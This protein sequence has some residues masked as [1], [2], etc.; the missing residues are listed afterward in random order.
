MTLSVDER[1]SLVRSVGEECIQEEELRGLLE[2][3]EE[4]I[5]YDGF[6]PCGRVH[7]G[8]G[9]V[10]ALTVQKLLKAGCRF[11]FWVADY[12][13]FLNNKM[14]GDMKKIQNIGKYM[15]EVWKAL[16]LNLDKVEFL[17]A[18]EE[19]NK[20]PGSYW[21]LVMDIARK[22]K[23]PRILNCSESMGRS[24]AGDVM[25]AQIM[26]PCMQ[27]ADILYLGADICQLGTDQQQ[28]NL[29]ARDY[30]DESGRAQKPVIVS[31]HVLRGLQEGQEKIVLGDPSSAIYM[32][33]TEVEV[34]TKIKK[35]FCPPKVTQGNPC[36]EYVKYVVLPAC[37]TFEV[38][39][40]DQNGGNKVYSS[41]DDLIADYES[42]ALHP[43][44]LKPS[45]A[46]AI[47]AI[48]EPVREYFKA[49]AEARTLQTQIVK[50]KVSA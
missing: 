2:R 48:L 33:D 5:C 31:H 40:S 13:A 44:D 9:V 22:H 3:K 34:K 45:L 25:T 30:C 49:N 8:V 38:E 10:K 6:E 20:N 24:S 42:E 32:E 4:P 23:L 18:S 39:R 43:G 37:G 26:Y 50:L 19:I 12:H 27:C 28:V 17:W 15:I 7:I 41:A 29:M 1:F 46:K 16:G 21:P 36:I 35:A 14:G 47:N 11:K